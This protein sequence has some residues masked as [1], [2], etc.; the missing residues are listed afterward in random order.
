[1]N[2]LSRYIW[3]WVNCEGSIAVAFTITVAA[4]ALVPFS[5]SSIA[6]FCNMFQIYTL[7]ASVV[8]YMFEKS[9]PHM[10]NADV[11]P[12]FSK[13]SLSCTL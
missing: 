4:A 9:A 10:S 1:M 8:S 12:F 7:N 5:S 2:G 11:I 3:I 6:V 13:Y